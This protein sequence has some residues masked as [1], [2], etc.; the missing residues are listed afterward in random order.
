MACAA[1]L[2]AQDT[3][4][5]ARM[6]PHY[7]TER[8]FYTTNS[9]YEKVIDT[10]I[11]RME[12]FHP[13]IRRHVL[14]QDLGNI[15]S[16]AQSLLFSLPSGSAFRLG[17]DA[18]QQYYLTPQDARYYQVKRP[19][20][21]FDYVQGAKELLFLKA[22][23]TQN[24]TARWN[25]GVNFRRIAS[26][27]YYTN[28]RSSIWSTQLFSSYRSKNQRYTALTTLQWNKGFVEMNGG[29]TSD[30]SFEALTGV[31]KQVEVNLQGTNP[32]GGGGPRNYFRNT[33]LEHTNYFYLGKRT[34]VIQG[35][36]T[37]QH[38]YS[39]GFIR[40][41]LNV[42]RYSF[43]FKDNNLLNKS[44]YPVFLFDTTKTYDSL[45]A[46]S[47]ANEFTYSNA[48]GL[49]RKLE[50]DLSAKH[51]YLELAQYGSNQVFHNTFASAYAGYL[52]IKNSSVFVSTSTGI[53]GYNAGDYYLMAGVNTRA[54]KQ[55][56]I[57]L[58]AEQKA[59][60]PDYLAARFVSN[61]FLWNNNFDKST[62]STLRAALSTRNWRHNATLNIK[63]HTVQSLVY[64]G[65]DG[66]PAQYGSA[67][68]I[69]TAE[70]NKTFQWG[71][72]F[73]TNQL[74]MQQVDDDAVLRLPALGAFER[75]YY[76]RKLF[77][78]ML[79]QIG[80]DVFYHSAFYANVFNP[81]TRQFQL[82]DSVKTGNYPVVDVFINAQIKKA[83]I[84]FK[85][86]HA[87]A[88]LSGARYYS[89][90]HQPIGHRSF[91]FGLTW[92]MYD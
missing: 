28:Q 35:K 51:Q 61:H 14:I 55:L 40:H 36:D 7:A 48:R 34:E 69:V 43:L 23:H 91:R 33:T 21:S 47:A 2:S 50:F 79:T 42:E 84:F 12:I 90:P 30:S 92:R 20:T 75:F 9:A 81:V 64:Y 86:E 18:M 19:F 59:A 56:N 89:S 46:F 17:T 16:P 66:T 54:G 10:T 24:I 57:L 22:L 6:A 58:M 37:L 1:T 71:N 72:F 26:A 29:I 15:G 78:V 70:L 87:N 25:A 13:V 53:T 73:L 5:A 88:D 74:Y 3:S 8:N 85:L 44:Y 76:Q 68:G 62:S 49:G 82:Q 41:K 27:G 65:A 38:R 52:G 60:E 77:K 80:V 63:Y 11:D 39:N 67:I 45:H 4:Y 83:A 32:T 31:N